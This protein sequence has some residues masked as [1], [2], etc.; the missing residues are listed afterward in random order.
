LVVVI[1][2][3]SSKVKLPKHVIIAMAHRNCTGTASDYFVYKLQFWRIVT[4]SGTASPQ[5]FSSGL[6]D[7][8]A[9]TDAKRP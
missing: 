5:N 3:A 9:R 7:Q 2:N 1:I 8:K 6:L 4:A